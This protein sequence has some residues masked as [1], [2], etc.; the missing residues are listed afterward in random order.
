[1]KDFDV[2]TVELGTSAGVA[3]DYIADPKNLPAWTHAFKAVSDGRAT[4]A[5]HQGP[6]EIGLEVRA[7]RQHG[8]VDWIMTLPGGGHAKAFSR[9]VEHGDGNA[10]FTFVLKAPPAS[11]ERA[12]GTLAEQTKILREELRRLQ[13]ILSA[14]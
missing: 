8:T 12:E 1:M 7:S 5:T 10:L 2:Q 13:E 11:L 14:G 3:F 9:L 4:L 6:V